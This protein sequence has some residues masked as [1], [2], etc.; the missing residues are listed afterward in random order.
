MKTD[1]TFNLFMLDKVANEQSHERINELLIEG[2]EIVLTYKGLRDWVWFTNKRL[3]TMDVQ[4]ITG[5]KKEFRSF[6]YSKITAFAIETAGSFD[7]DSEF[8]IWLSGYGAFELKFGK[9]INILEINQFL[10]S[11]IL[12]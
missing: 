10:T 8:K 6:P 11:K 3:I 4:G 7:F 2:E 5:K 12:I 1:F 9:K